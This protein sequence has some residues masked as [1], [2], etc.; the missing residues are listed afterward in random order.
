MWTVWCI[1]QNENPEPPR[2]VQDHLLLVDTRIVDEGHQSPTSILA[3][4]AKCLEGAVDEL[5]EDIRVL[6]AVENLDRDHLVLRHGG[7]EAQ[8]VA[9]L[10]R[11]VGLDL[12]LGEV[13]DVLMDS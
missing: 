8:T 2:R 6:G 3:G 9:L 1:K 11:L 12:D 5:F 13:S 4:P 7:S 10:G